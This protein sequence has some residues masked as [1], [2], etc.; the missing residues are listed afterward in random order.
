M[1]E[2]ISTMAAV[3]R[4][5]VYVN[6]F[7]NGGGMTVRIGCDAADTVA[8]IGS[9]AGAV[10]S[11]DGCSPSRPM[12]VMAFHGTADPLVDY[13]GQDI[14]SEPLLWGARATHTPTGFLG[15]EEWVS[16]WAQGNGCDSEP[17]AIPP[18]GEVHGVRYVQCDDNAEVILYT[19]EGGG[20]TWPGGFPIPVGRTSK[21]IDA[22]E[23]LWRFFQR[24]SLDS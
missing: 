6:G 21:D 11:M 5:R 12:P 2:D 14:R 23:E 9:V 10:V 18:Q 3:D 17:E 4:T 1:L 13:A 22:T 24:Y 8:A 15:A 20:H 16:L 7:S 19:I